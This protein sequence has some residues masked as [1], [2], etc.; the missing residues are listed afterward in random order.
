MNSTL[1]PTY[2]ITLFPT[3]TNSSGSGDSMGF[4][5][6]FAPLFI[7]LSFFSITI[8]F[9]LLYAKIHAYYFGGWRT[10]GNADEIRERGSAAANGRFKMRLMRDP[11]YQ[12]L[13]P[14]S[15]Y[16]PVDD[17]SLECSVCLDTISSGELCRKLPD[18][19]GHTFHSQCILEWFSYSDLCPLCKRSVANILR[20]SH[21]F[22][23]LPSGLPREIVVSGVQS[24]ISEV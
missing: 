13:I 18:P 22:Q 10:P 5:I 3:A 1:S 20:S 24:E 14:E 6:I 17:S 2:S 23:C 15:P 21:N 11:Y 12:A 8:S 4:Q 16:S 19:C 7:A 9:I